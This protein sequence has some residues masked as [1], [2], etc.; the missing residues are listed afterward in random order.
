[1]PSGR[2]RSWRPTPVR[3]T[4]RPG[5]AHLAAKSAGPR[6]AYDREWSGDGGH[7]W[8]QVASTTQAKTSITGLPAGKTVQFRFRSVTPKGQT[9]WCQPV[10]FLV[11]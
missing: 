10:S 3:T 5:S 7:T 8:R 6:A 9:D 4:P 11:K 2:S 1:V